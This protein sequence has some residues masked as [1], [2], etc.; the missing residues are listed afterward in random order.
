MR[1][2]RT[3]LHRVGQ[4][5]DWELI[6]KQDRNVWQRLAFSTKGVVTPANVTSVI[7]AV[8]V[9]LGLWYFYIGYSG[10]GIICVAFGRL[11]DILDGAVAQATGTKSGVGEAIDASIDKITILAALIVFSIADIVPL[12]VIALIALRN[13][14]NIGLSLIARARKKILHPSRAGKLAAASEWTTLLFFI[15][16]AVTDNQD[17]SIFSAATAVVACVALAVTMMLGII[18]TKSYYLSLKD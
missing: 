17:W 5:A 18:A 1:L 12:A 11:A 16:A 9:G 15:L 10:W 2:L 14:V 7:G 8:L 6:A 4:K 13:S 3:S